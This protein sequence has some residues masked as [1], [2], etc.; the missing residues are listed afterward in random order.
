MQ[1]FV[2]GNEAIDTFDFG[3]AGIRCGSQ[4]GSSAATYID[5]VLRRVFAKYEWERFLGAQKGVSIIRVSVFD[6]YRI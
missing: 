3:N 4:P 1:F 2:D 6:A 5:D